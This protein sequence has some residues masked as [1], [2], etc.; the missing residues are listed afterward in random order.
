MK[1]PF[2]VGQWSCNG[3]DGELSVAVWI[4]GGKKDKF[5]CATNLSPFRDAMVDDTEKH[6]N[7]VGIE[8]V[9]E[10]YEICRLLAER[11]EDDPLV[12]DAIKL[13]D[14]MQKKFVTKKRAAA[15]KE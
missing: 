3:V 11:D 8:A 4:E 9:P 5:I 15:K 7:C 6:N 13:M 14:K 2:T 1:N 12:Q 10:M